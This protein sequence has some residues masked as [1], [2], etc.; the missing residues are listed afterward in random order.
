MCEL[1]QRFIEEHMSLL[2]ILY[3]RL[4]RIEGE[5]AARSV[6]RSSSL[7]SAEVLAVRDPEAAIPLNEAVATINCILRDLRNEVA[8]ELPRHLGVERCSGVQGS[9]SADSEGPRALPAVKRAL[10][11][12]LHAELAHHHLTAGHA[13]S[14]VSVTLP[15]PRG[16]STG[17]PTR[18]QLLES[19]LRSADCS[20]F[21][22]SVCSVFSFFF[23]L[24]FFN[25][26]SFYGTFLLG[27]SRV[28]LHQ[29]V[30]NEAASRD[31]DAAGAREQTARDAGAT[32]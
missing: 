25:D 16:T 21:S 1:T 18:A 27:F 28:T 3:A 6:Q 8:R 30:G 29:A 14:T 4:L 31:A 11:D 23:F 20:L 32:R 24:F 7:P 5:P 15:S 13:T 12:S 9:C 19:E 17:V 22:L 26:Y 2:Q 10:L